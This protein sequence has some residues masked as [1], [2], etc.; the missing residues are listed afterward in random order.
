MFFTLKQS[1]Y[2]YTTN[3][4][5]RLITIITVQVYTIELHN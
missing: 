1:V 2:N 4:R 5:H 3:N